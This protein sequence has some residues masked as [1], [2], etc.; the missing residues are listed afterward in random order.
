M[1][2][3]L[4][5][6]IF[7]ALFLLSMSACSSTSAFNLFSSKTMT[8]QSARVNQQAQFASL[9][10][11]LQKN[12]QIAQTKKKVN[13]IHDAQLLLENNHPRWAVNK[14][15][16]MPNL[17]NL[18][19]EQLIY[20]YFLA[21]Q[22]YLRMDSLSYSTLARMTLNDYLPDTISRQANQTIIWHS[23]LML[24]SNQLN[25]LLQKTSSDSTRGWLQ[26]AW[27]AKQNANNPAQLSSALVA[28]KTSFPTHPA[29]FLLPSQESIL[30]TAQ[31]AL[32]AHIALL[33][34][35]HGQL[36]EMGKAV[37]N[38]FMGAFYTHN[39]QGSTQA[40]TIKFYDTSQNIS[41]VD[42]Y[43]QAVNEGAQF[44]IGPLTKEDVSQL[45]RHGNLS[46][47]TLG[48]NVLF[49]NQATPSN[50]IQF[51]LLPEQETEQVAEMMWQYGLKNILF[52]FP[53]GDWGN[54]IRTT[55]IDSWQRMGGS[56]P[57]S[58]S[59]SP[60]MDLKSAVIQALNVVERQDPLAKPGLKQKIQIER[61]QDLDGI[62][63]PIQ[64]GLAR[65]V[66]PLL[67]YYYAGNLPLFSISSIYSGV[68]NPIK[69]NDL[70]ETLF[71][72]MPW[73]LTSTA[74]DSLKAQ[75]KSLWPSHYAR[76][77]QLYALG[78]DSYLIACL[79]P[80][81]TALPNFPIQGVTG[82]LFFGD[83]QVINRQ[84]PFA[85]FKNGYPQLW[86]I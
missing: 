30:N 10:Q 17:K 12:I 20:Y 58:L 16:S 36:G 74:Y 2:R 31:T 81:L 63:M 42:L 61:R 56:I 46:V 7:S 40:P 66:E 80:R 19:S 75:F 18:S 53:E 44:I 23:L 64:P 34:P 32:P 27:I 54:R 24:S 4:I 65:Q 38:G 48:L 15:H 35:L 37:Q 45:A 13:E 62:F 1:F 22:A 5:Y 69:D 76:Y 52:L 26:L 25:I 8:F 50:L 82:Q 29:N 43:Q 85:Q 9:N 59:L 60:G 21:S 14:L 11:T 79:L 49:E 28:W 70:N 41:I 6:T 72:S 68:P 71:T 78:I 39:P 51:G 86:L 55:F 57:V 3:Q 77:S 67:R 47:P 83:H 33:L 73:L 84:L